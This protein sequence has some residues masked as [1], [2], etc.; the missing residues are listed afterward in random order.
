MAKLGLTR[1]PLRRTVIHEMLH[2]YCNSYECWHEATLLE[3]M[4]SQ[5]TTIVVQRWRAPEPKG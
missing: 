2:C 1:S 4:V 5:V 3:E